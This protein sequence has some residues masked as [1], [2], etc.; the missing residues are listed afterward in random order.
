M[1]KHNNKQECLVYYSS[2]QRYVIVPTKIKILFALAFSVY[3][4]FLSKTITDTYWLSVV[5][6]VICWKST[7]ILSS[8]LLFLHFVCVVYIWLLFERGERFFFVSLFVMQTF[9][10]GGGRFKE[11]I[12]GRPFYRSATCGYVG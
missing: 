11:V 10:G 3:A 9:L 5:F 6:G 12:R 1:L 8:L 7:T 2:L 4:R